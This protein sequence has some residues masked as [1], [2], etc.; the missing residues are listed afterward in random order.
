[1]FFELLD[2]TTELAADPTAFAADPTADDIDPSI[3][4]ELELL[5]YTMV[6]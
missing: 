5:I 3:P 4:A 6:V 1:L 2:P